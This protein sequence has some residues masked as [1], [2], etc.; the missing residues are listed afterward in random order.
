VNYRVI[1]VL[2]SL[3]AYREESACLMDERAF[4]RLELV[5]YLVGDPVF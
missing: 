4:L 1:F 5:C 2:S 3:E